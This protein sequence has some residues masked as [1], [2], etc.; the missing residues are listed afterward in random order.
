MTRRVVVTGARGFIG[1]HLTEAL[2]HRGDAVAT[3]IVRAPCDQAA[4][5]ATFRGAE[6][7][8][9]LAGVVAAG[10]DHLFTAGNVDAT[11]AVAA[12]ASAA[13]A[14]LVHISSLAAAGPAPPSSP[15]DEDDV[16]APVTAYGASKLAGERVVRA[17]PALRWTILRPGVVYGPRDRGL[18]TLFQFANR[19]CL[20]L[21]GR[22]TA[23]FTFIEVRDVVRAIVAAV[24][25]R[26]ESET[27]FVGHPAPVFARDLLELIRRAVNP[28]AW[29]VRVPTPVL[30]L[31]A[32]ASEAG[33]WLTGRSAA[34]NRRRYVELT[35]PG[36]VCRVDRLRDRL[37]V[38]AQID[39][40]EGIGA[41]AAWY[42]DA[43]WIEDGAARTT[44]RA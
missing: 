22:S 36:F 20:P 13:G 6:C 19:G 15:R 17:T 24:D 11:R 39:L 4:L 5:A 42:R 38:I 12:A 25:R 28:R 31:V 8:V 43:G 21:V 14:H 26:L 23:A 35:S 41:A 29:I 44:P 40:A 7:V 30:A 9:H 32:A 10:R 34:V 16:C 2:R 1:S 18:F 33:R 37:G 3:A 27:L